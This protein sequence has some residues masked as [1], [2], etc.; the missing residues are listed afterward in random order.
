MFS[1]ME[2]KH[3][4][5]R[6]THNDCCGHH[7]FSSK[8]RE[9]NLATVTHPERLQDHFNPL[10]TQSDRRSVLGIPLDFPGSRDFGE[11]FEQIDN[12]FQFVG[13]HR[14]RVSSNIMLHDIIDFG[15]CRPR[16]SLLRDVGGA[17]NPTVQVAAPKNDSDV[18]NEMRVWLGGESVF[19]L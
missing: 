7:I 18:L 8:L 15:S 14:C 6:G 10:P 5:N 3:L 19:P 17:Y 16:G 9:L 13:R 12:E 4:S 11:D 2:R 1:Y